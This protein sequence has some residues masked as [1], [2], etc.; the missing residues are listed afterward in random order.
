MTGALRCA[1]DGAWLFVSNSMPVRDLDSYGPGGGRDVSVVG[2]RGASGIDGIVS[3]AAGVSA[4]AGARVV[5]VLGDLAFYHDMN[6]LLATREPDVD[7][8]F[9]VIHNDGGGL[10][11]TLPIREFEPAF[12]AH[13][14]TPHGLDFRHTAALYDLPYQRCTTA[15]ELDAA[16]SQGVA[17]GGSRVIEVP[18]DREENRLHREQAAQRVADAVSRVLSQ[19]QK[20]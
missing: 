13:F 20:E 1:R 5:C 2:N 10:F 15:A 9:V 17:A 11:H 16:I 18:T 19:E 8:V 12:T 7:V 3:T 14:A 4:G 6:G